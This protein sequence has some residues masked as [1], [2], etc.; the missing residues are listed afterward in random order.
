MNFACVAQVKFTVFQS[1]PT[2]LN[3]IAMLS[4]SLQ[5]AAIPWEDV[6]VSLP[7]CR[8]HPSHGLHPAG[9]IVVLLLDREEVVSR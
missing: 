5:C 2:A 9:R 4:V 8:G 1:Y 7:G 6:G 3:G